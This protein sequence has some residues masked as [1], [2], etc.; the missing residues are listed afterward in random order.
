MREA[1]AAA[2][3]FRAAKSARASQKGHPTVIS[4]SQLPKKGLILPAKACLPARVEG[5]VKMLSGRP[6]RLLRAL[7]MRY[8]DPSP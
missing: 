7:T 8:R 1:L 4:L 2:G 3:G 5:S 6:I